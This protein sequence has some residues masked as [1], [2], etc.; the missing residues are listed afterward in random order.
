MNS[1]TK[2][3]ITTVE[4]LDSYI[5]WLTKHKV[6]ATYQG[7]APQFSPE[8]RQLMDD[9]NQLTQLG[10]AQD[11]EKAVNGFIR[12]LNR[13]P[14]FVA[15]RY[16]LAHTLKQLGR[17]DE[18]LEHYQAAVQYNPN[19]PEI[20]IELGDVYYRLGQK[21]SEIVS[22]FQALT[23]APEDNVE[24]IWKAVKNIGQTFG[25]IRE[26]RKSL[27]FLQM[28]L[29]IV[30]ENSKHSISP[31]AWNNE[32]IATYLELGNTYKYMGN[33]QSAEKMYL[34]G[35]KIG[36]NTKSPVPHLIYHE[37]MTWSAI[38]DLYLSQEQWSK[39]EQFAKKCVERY[40]QEQLFQMKLRNAKNRGK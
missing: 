25:E 14:N 22:Y 26:Y 36:A 20:Y 17:F 24:L 33:N 21:G 7:G 4:Q 15:A 6:V 3:R 30:I 38:T 8:M 5:N 16:N 12:I 23:L 35:I 28:A 27:K 32:F 1:N 11:P 13:Y 19:D 10:R 2:D 18:A 39:A 31:E 40:P 37:T 29:D 34:E 9:Y